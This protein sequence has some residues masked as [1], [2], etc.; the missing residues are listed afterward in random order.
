[1]NHYIIVVAESK[2]T[3]E[4]LTAREIFGLLIPLKV[5][6]FREEA[7]G[8][9]NIKA[10]DKIIFYLAGLNARYFA[11]SATVASDIYIK[12]KGSPD[13]LK[14]KGK[15][16]FPKRIDLKDIKVWKEPLPIKPLIQRLDFIKNK[17]SYGLYMRRTALSISEKDYKVVM[18]AAGS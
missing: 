5:W 11:G 14:E 18:K 12:R 16:Y 13:P 17:D 1:M 15:R 10:G 9:K 2:G 4:D 7:S 8:I 6:D 3:G